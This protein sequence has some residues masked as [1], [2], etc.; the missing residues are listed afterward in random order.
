[1]LLWSQVRQAR[2]RLEREYQSQSSREASSSKTQFSWLFPPSGGWHLH[3][4]RSAMDHY[5]PAQWHL[6]PPRTQGKVKFFRC[7][8][9]ILVV[10]SYSLP[11]IISNTKTP[12]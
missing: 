12:V 4:G 8:S 3:W 10:S 5:L 1:V 2:G 11:A 6:T 7:V 9:S